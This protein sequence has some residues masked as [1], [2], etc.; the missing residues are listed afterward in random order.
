MLL[1][2]LCLTL[3][4]LRFLHRLV[5]LFVRVLTGVCSRVNAQPR[6]V[7]RLRLLRLL[8]SSLQ[9]RLLSCSD[10]SS[11]NGG[12]QFSSICL[13]HMSSR[14]SFQCYRSSPCSGPERCGG[15]GGG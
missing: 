10:Q 4:R 14:R 3:L 11:S 9:F 7:V 12:S 15:D 6:S 5:L 8:L 1:S 2:A 13:A